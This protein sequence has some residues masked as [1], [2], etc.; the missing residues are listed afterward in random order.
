MYSRTSRKAL[1]SFILT[2]PEGNNVDKPS[3]THARAEPLWTEAE[4][5]LF[6][7]VIRQYMW[8][9][10]TG[11]SPLSVATVV[12]DACSKED[13]L[14]LSEF[15]MDVRQLMWTGKYSVA[16]SNLRA[17][18]R[19]FVD[20]HSYFYSAS[21]PDEELVTLEAIFKN[22]LIRKRRRGSASSM[23]NGVLASNERKHEEVL[24]TML[25][26]TQRSSSYPSR[27]TQCVMAYTRRFV[28]CFL[29]C[30]FVYV[31]GKD[32][33]F[34]KR[35]PNEAENKKLEDLFGKLRL[36]TKSKRISPTAPPANNGGVS[37][38]KLAA[39]SGRS[40]DVKT[41]QAAKNNNKI[42]HS[43]TGNIAKNAGSLSKENMTS[44]T[45]NKT[46]APPTCL[47][48]LT[49]NSDVIHFGCL[50]TCDY[51]NGCTKQG[52]TIL[53]T[54]GGCDCPDGLLWDIEVGKCVPPALCPRKLCFCSGFGG[55]HYR[56]YDGWYL[57]HTGRCTYLLSETTHMSANDSCY[58]RITGRN[59]KIENLDSQTS[60]VDHI[61]IKIGRLKEWIRLLKGNMIQIGNQT[62][63]D[64]S[65]IP[66][67]Y[68]VDLGIIFNQTDASQTLMEDTLCGLWVSYG[69]YRFTIKSRHHAGKLRGICG[70]CND[71][72]VDDYKRCDTGKVEPESDHQTESFGDSCR[73]VDPEFDGDTNCTTVPWDWSKNGGGKA[74]KAL[75]EG[76][77]TCADLNEVKTLKQ[78]MTSLPYY[79]K[80]EINFA[81]VRD[82][83]GIRSPRQAKYVVCAAIDQIEHECMSRGSVHVRRNLLCNADKLCTGNRYLS[84]TVKVGCQKTCTSLANKKT[85]KGDIDVGC[86][87]PEGYLWHGYNRTCIPDNSCGERCGENVCGPGLKCFP[88]FNICVAS[89][90][91]PWTP[92]GKD[93]D[94]PLD[95][96]E[97]RP[98]WH[99]KV[100]E[101]RR[102][103][104]QKQLLELAKRAKAAANGDKTAGT[105]TDA[106]SVT[107]KSTATGTAA[108]TSAGTV[109]A[110]ETDE[111]LKKDLRPLFPW[112]KPVFPFWSMPFGLR[113][114]VSQTGRNPF[115]RHNIGNFI[116]GIFNSFP[117]IPKTKG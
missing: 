115:T 64:I 11:G 92:I 20:L 21:T 4:I 63:R 79:T 93:I 36:G 58:H 28:A 101:E 62:F 30:S 94:T 66:A 24:P 60:W 69:N 109:Q 3:S 48:N 117:Q 29:F 42:N 80:K 9:L 50:K 18:T 91:I 61:N 81:C 27:N 103:E 53:K 87:C 49:W 83:W 2:D 37:Q 111:L 112:L 31:T 98:A 110:K 85:C 12:L 71:N 1:F 51:P 56:T 89:D 114:P 19:Y 105:A 82:Q 72:P 47:Y 108:D 13:C 8:K 107:A 6:W 97:N 67:H 95:H 33:N 38:Q 41:Q 102:K 34:V 26:R 100:I 17:L 78:C 43:T 84:P 90:A 14:Q 25:L 46:I 68:A 22:R 59:T 96:P 55:L 74:V 40:G 77:L 15:L 45:L 35:G 70:D 106:A 44:S 7:R 88:T 116:N 99:W 75:S 32:F 113:P 23:P 16:V 54:T 10:V 65:H 5:D 73:V 76:S 52:K 57:H 39:T 86:D 104:R